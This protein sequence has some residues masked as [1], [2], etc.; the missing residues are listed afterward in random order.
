MGCWLLAGVRR[1]RRSLG[2][3]W[4]LLCGSGLVSPALAGDG[5]PI[6]VC[7]EDD[8]SYPWQF[9][10][11]AGLTDLLLQ[12]VSARAEVV[13]DVKRKPWRR[14]LDELKAGAVDAVYKISYSPE[15]AEF[16]QYPLREGKLDLGRRL[17]MDSYS[18]YRKKGTD[19]Q[20][21]GKV[22][23]VGGPIGVQT[24]F[25]IAVQ[26][27]ALGVQTDDGSRSAAINLQKLL[28]DRVAAV[29]LQTEEGDRSLEADAELR[30]AIERV[31]PVLVEKPYFLVFARHYFAQNATQAEAIWNAI[32]IERESAGYKET[33]RN[34]R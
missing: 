19:V 24:G 20:W 18:L 8:D 9:R 25:S 11:R 12:R 21:D 1:L 17:H 2:A 23:R 13:F 32:G 33:V 28:Y 30:Q 29:A 34:F 22:L 7:T 27:H 15:R 5:K 3:V 10:D 26:L 14:C 4:F 31:R 16:A 6:Q